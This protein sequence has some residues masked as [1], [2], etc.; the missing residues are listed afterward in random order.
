LQALRLS[1]WQ[2]AIKIGIVGFIAMWALDRAFRSEREIRSL[3]ARLERAHERI[4]HLEETFYDRV[5]GRIEALMNI[6]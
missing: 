3:N 5:D 2:S 6:K 1:P 4:A